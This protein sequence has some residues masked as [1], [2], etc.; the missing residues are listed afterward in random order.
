VFHLHLL[1]LYRLVI[2]TE[3]DDYNS[4]LNF[5][6]SSNHCRPHKL[7]VKL[8][9]DRMFEARAILLGRMNNH[10]GAL[11]IYIYRLEAYD[12]AEA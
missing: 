9:D 5:L 12:K 4:L 3:S 1:N 7:I 8:P 2:P 6:N 10:S 11:Q